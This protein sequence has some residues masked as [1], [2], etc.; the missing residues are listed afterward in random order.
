MGNCCSLYVILC[1]CMKALKMVGLA[2]ALFGLD[3][4][5]HLARFRSMCAQSANFWSL[6]I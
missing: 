6:L 4:M 5:T 2:L 3:V 1:A